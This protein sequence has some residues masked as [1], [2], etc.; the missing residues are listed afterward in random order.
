MD[1]GQ[2]LEKY[3]LEW[4]EHYFR[5]RDSFHKNIVSIS[6]NKST[7]EIEYKGGKER[8]IAALYL[9]E[10]KDEI[11]MNSCII[12]L[13]NRS[14][15]ENLYNNWPRFS[16]IENLKIYFINPLSTTEKKWIINPKVHNRICDESSL[17]TGLMAMFGTVEPVTR[18]ILEKKL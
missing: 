3:F 10:L 14:N 4:A 8:I 2:E 1:K 6:H 12:T 11:G 18:E 15:V 9:D 13:N 16:K 7:M 5:S 17:K